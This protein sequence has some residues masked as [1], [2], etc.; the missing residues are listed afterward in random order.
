M[1]VIILFSLGTVVA[2]ENITEEVSVCDD[3]HL[4][5]GGIQAAGESLNDEPENGRDVLGQDS[6]PSLEAISKVDVSIRIDVESAYDGKTYNCEGLEVP[7][8]I[9]VKA[10]SGNA[11]NVVVR[12]YLSSN[13]QYITHNLTKGTF[14]SSI[15]VWNVGELKDSESASLTIMTKLLSNGTFTNK[16]DVQT[17][18]LDKDKS[19]NEATLSIETGEEDDGSHTT[20]TT[21]DKNKYNAGDHYASEGGGGVGRQK[22]DEGLSNGPGGFSQP[23]EK[24]DKPQTQTSTSD[25]KKRHKS[26]LTRSTSSFARSI[27]SPVRALADMLDPDSPSGNDSSEANAS[28]SS[29]SKGFEAIPPYDYSTIPL[30]VFG[31]FLLA[32]FAI[33]AGDKIRSSRVSDN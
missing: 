23:P 5:D 31:L 8:T 3:A 9:T 11:Y 2:G 19:N 28:L 29:P 24:N 25:S 26:G 15:G 7:W 16:A 18:S 12:D 27:S 22:V 21:D 4:D 6:S 32:L 10:K 17:G 33:V 20:E 13:L 30:S 14:D 1:A